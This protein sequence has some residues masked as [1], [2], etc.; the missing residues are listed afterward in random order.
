MLIPH[1]GNESVVF[2]YGIVA[3]KVQK[4]PQPPNKVADFLRLVRILSTV[5][6]IQTVLPD[7]SFAFYL[8]DFSV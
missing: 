2:S 3:A 7:K 4:N 6:V 1:S 8:K 5:W